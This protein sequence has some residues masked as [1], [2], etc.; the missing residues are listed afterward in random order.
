MSRFYFYFSCFFAVKQFFSTNSIYLSISTS[1]PDMK[2]EIS[3]GMWQV[4]PES[5]IKLAICE[6]SPKSLLGLPILEDIRYIDLYI[7]CEL[8]C[9]VL[10][11]YAWYILSICTHKFSYFL[12]SSVLYFLNFRSWTICD[13]VILWY[14]SSSIYLVFDCYVQYTYF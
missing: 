11:S 3:G 6:L 2:Y 8:I 12:C 14:T 9:S 4:A 10:L 5:K 7:F 13:P 1:E